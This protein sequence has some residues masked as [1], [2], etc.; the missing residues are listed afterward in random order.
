M[1]V[2]GAVCPADAEGPL[3]VLQNR[4]LNQQRVSGFAFDHLQTIK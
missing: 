2:A 1:P 4:Y 3:I